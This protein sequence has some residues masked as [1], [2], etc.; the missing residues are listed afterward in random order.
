MR[1]GIFS[2]EFVE[3]YGNI[4]LEKCIICGV[5]YLRDFDIRIVRKVYDYLI[6]RFCDNIKCCGFLVDFIIN[7]GESL[8][9][10]DLIKLY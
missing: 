4:N 3:F 7:F 1:S 2:D 9:D 5:K 8:F 10:D 6:G